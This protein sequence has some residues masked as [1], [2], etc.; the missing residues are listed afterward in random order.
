MCR[1][2]PEGVR[3][4]FSDTHDHHIRGSDGGLLQHP[5]FV[6]K[7]ALMK[8]SFKTLVLGLMMLATSIQGFA[9]ATMM[10]CEPVH[11]QMVFAGQSESVHN[12]H[13]HAAAQIPVEHVVS[14]NPATHDHDH[15]HG[16]AKCNICS[17]CCM[18]V[19]MTAPE[20]LSISPL[21]ISSHVIPFFATVIRGFVPESLERPPRNILA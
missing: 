20:F 8:L 3:T 9:A 1:K 2:I 15:H 21:P 13:H 4:H 12:M 16:A 5:D 17:A 7:S 11:E 19:A 14:R 10:F 18:L 6:I